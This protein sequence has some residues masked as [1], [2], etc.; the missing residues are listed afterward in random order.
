MAAGWHGYSSTYYS[1]AW[2]AYPGY[3]SY[4]PYGYS[5]G[6]PYGG[7]SL[8]VNFGYPYWGWSAGWGYPYYGSWGYPYYASS[9]AWYPYRTLY[10]G[11]PWVGYY[12]TYPYPYLASYDYYDCDFYSGYY[13]RFG[14]QRTSYYVECSGY[15]RHDPGCHHCHVHTCSVHGTHSYHLRDCPLCY[16]SGGVVLHDVEVPDPPAADAAPMESGGLVPEAEG[17][18][19]RDDATSSDA[20]PE[21]ERIPLGREE[22]FFSSLKPAQLSLALGLIQFQNGEYDEAVESF[23]NGTLEDPK[24]RVLKLFLAT[25]LAAIGEYEHAAGYLRLTLQGW[26]AFPAYPWNLRDLY[27][28]VADLE[29]HLGLLEEAIRLNPADVDARLVLAFSQF[30]GGSPGD[31]ARSFEAVSAL[32][33]DP[34][35][36]AIAGAYREEHERRQGLRPAE[37]AEVESLLLASDAEDEAVRRFLAS[38]SLKDIPYLPVR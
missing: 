18:V 4:Y 30:H 22:A 10:C 26:A 27:G 5:Y 25:S 15:G 1:R 12:Y 13:V 2:Y 34:V 37:G 35:D 32:S 19:A 36:D 33:G 17:A 23:Y 29:K 7:W 9:Y 11:Y 24:S 3:G 38:L 16:P 14:P 31:A 28:N 21:L 8:S 6:Y 20:A